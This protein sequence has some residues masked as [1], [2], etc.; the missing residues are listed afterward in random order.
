MKMVNVMKKLFYRNGKR[1]AFNLSLII[2]IIFSNHYPAIA[3]INIGGYVEN[4]GLSGFGAVTTI[5][6]TGTVK[7]LAGGT[8]GGGGSVTNILPGGTFIVEEGGNFGGEFNIHVGANFD[9]YADPG[10]SFNIIADENGNSIRVELSGAGNTVPY[11]R[12]VFPDGSQ[13]NFPSPETSRNGSNSGNKALLSGKYVFTVSENSGTGSKIH[14][15]IGSGDAVNYFWQTGSWSLCDNTCGEGTQT[16]YVACADSSGN[17]AADDNCSG[18]KPDVTRNCY[19]DS[20]CD[21]SG[22]TDH[23]SLDYNPRD[24]KIG[25]TELLRGIQ[26]YNSDSYHCDAGGEDGYSPG[27]GDRNCVPHSSDY[28]PQDWKIGLNELLRLIQLYNSSGYYADSEGED[29]FHPGEYSQH[30]NT[31]EH[32]LPY[33][34]KE[35]CTFTLHT[36][37]GTSRAT[38][39]GNGWSESVMQSGHIRIVVQNCVIVENPQNVPV[40]DESK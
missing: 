5:T 9:V 1:I 25:L 3:G 28:N 16:R 7:T 18:I 17:T 15:V 40:Y 4:S 24:D 11:G 23:H 36:E 34:T 21:S 22:D 13:E 32:D 35:G 39:S 2:A 33:V 12:L 10:E 14:L 27:S 31:S 29:G 37:N 20:G 8:F 19:D 30:P 26:L 6:E 38:S